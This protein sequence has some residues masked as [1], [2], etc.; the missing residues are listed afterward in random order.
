MKR[1]FNFCA[2]PAA[3][4]LEVLQEAQAEMCDF[5]GTG[6]SILEHSHRGKAYEAVHN[7][8][9][10]N[11]KSLLKLSDDYSVIFVQG[12]A[13]VQ[14]AMVPLN[15]LGAGQTADY[16]CSG[17]WASGPPTPGST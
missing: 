9:V 6:M 8:A 3:L 17:A 15:L 1:V 4:P 7:E 16:I 13:S 2:G 12:G 11:I 14:F 5:K 10:A